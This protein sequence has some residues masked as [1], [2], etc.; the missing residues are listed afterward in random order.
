MSPEDD[1][2]LPNATDSPMFIERPACVNC[3]AK[4]ASIVWE[5]RFGEE[6]TRCYIENFH[7]QGNLIN[8]L[9]DECFCLVRCNSCSMLYHRRILNGPFLSELYDQ[10]TNSDQ[11]DALELD[12]R[13]SGQKI[14]RLVK[15]KQYLKHILRLHDLLKNDSAPDRLILDYGCGDGIL[16]GAAS[17]LGW[18]V[19]GIDMSETR[20]ERAARRSNINIC[21]DLKSFDELESQPLHA[22]SLLQVLEHIKE[23]LDLLKQLAGRMRQ[24]GILIVEVPDCRGIGVPKNFTQ[25]RAVQPI[26]HLNAFTPSTLSAMCMRAGFTPI[27]RKPAH[28]TT[29]LLDVL[30]TEISRFYQPSRTNQYF[31]LTAECPDSRG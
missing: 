31:R 27:R 17:Y 13:K 25:Y 18:K 29:A 20:Q 16:L 10:A 26:E 5:G 1:S 28:V 14:S 15:R 30:K 2:R 22:I 4:G 21:P 9:W 12:L 8:R 7:Y 11:I 24:G 19:Y 3:A 23:P 6:P